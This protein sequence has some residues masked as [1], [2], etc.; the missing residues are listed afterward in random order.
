MSNIVSFIQGPLIW[1][2]LSIFVVGL[3]VRTFNLLKLTRKKEMLRF[4]PDQAFLSRTPLTKKQ[5]L[6][7]YLVFQRGSSLE[8][9][10]C[11]VL[12]SIVFHVCLIMT[13]LFIHGHNVLLD[14]SFGISLI[15]LPE[16]ISDIMTKFVLISGFILFLRRLL[17]RRVRI[18]STIYDYLLLLLVLAPFLTGFMA[19]RHLLDYNTLII[20]HMF[21]GELILIIIPFSKFFHMIFFFVS[22][23]MIASEH[24]FGT[25]SR[26]WH[27]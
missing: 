11:L 27:F 22:R 20:L 6:F 14:T 25:P 8:S 10:I 21:F 19:Y 4:E 16:K 3:I 2:S 15:S 23:F 7:R 18:I 24:S 1:I 13:P 17:L 12:I 26:T 5:R 9:N